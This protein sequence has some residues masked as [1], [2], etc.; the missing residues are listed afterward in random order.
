MTFSNLKNIYYKAI[1]NQDSMAL[2]QKQTP[3]MDTQLHGELIFYKAGK[4]IPWKKDS[5]F[6]KW[7]S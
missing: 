4:T 5:L 6:N 7:E 2:A 3:E 1:T